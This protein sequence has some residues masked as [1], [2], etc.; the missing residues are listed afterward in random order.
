MVAQLD[1]LRSTSNLQMLAQQSIHVWFSSGP[2]IL[3]TQGVVLNTGTEPLSAEK[4][5]ILTR[6][7]VIG[8]RL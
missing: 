3:A 5:A 6:I 1:I 4:G 8:T 2:F 7:Q